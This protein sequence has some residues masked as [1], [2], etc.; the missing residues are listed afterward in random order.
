MLDE[1]LGRVAGRLG[2]VEPQRRS[3][4]SCS[5]ST[6]V[7]PGRVEDAQHSA[8]LTY[9]ERARHTMIDQKLYLLR[10]WIS[11]LARCTTGDTRGGQVRDQTSAGQDNDHPPA[12]CWGAGPVNS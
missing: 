10:P 3:P 1:S 12:R 7:P 8:Y 11:D 5:A 4:S 6:P 9:A 2:W